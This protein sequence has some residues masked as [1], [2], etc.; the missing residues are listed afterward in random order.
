MLVLLWPAAAEAQLGVSA[1]FG[2]VRA[3]EGQG[4]EVRVEVDDG[5]GVIRQVR[6]SAR[7]P[8]GGVAPVEVD[9]TPGPGGWWTAL[10]PAAHVPAAGARLALTADLMGRRSG[11]I[12]ALGQEAPLLVTVM[13]AAAGAADARRVAEATAADGPLPIVGWVG[14]EARAGSGARAR[15]AIGA[16]AALGRR[17][18]LGVGVAVGPAFA[19]P[20]TLSEGGPVVL[21]LE[22]SGR[23]F[24]ASPDRRGAAPFLEPYLTADFRLPGLDA[25][26]GLRAGASW[27]LPAPIVIE[28]SLGGAVLAL[29][30][31]ERAALGF[32]GGLRVTARFGAPHRGPS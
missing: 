27:T 14:L 24:L 18:E 3:V 10:V 30:L 9:A 8:G 23:R 16:A 25:G 2:A 12:L 21:G 7:S 31:T 11:L 4:C 13:T 28:A 26:G 22:L 32:A 19:R 15:V 1:R 29:A 17:T 6:V 5:L 20:D